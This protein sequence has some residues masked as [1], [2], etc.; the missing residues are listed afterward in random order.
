MGIVIDILS[1][2]WKFIKTITFFNYTAPWITGICL[3][4]LILL[5]VYFTNYSARIASSL[6]LYIVDKNKDVE[7][8]SQLLADD[9]GLSVWLWWILAVFSI[10][11]IAWIV[12]FFIYNLLTL[13]SSKEKGIMIIF[14]LLHL[15]FIAGSAY[16]YIYYKKKNL[17]GLIERINIYFNKMDMNL[18][19]VYSSVYLVLICFLLLYYK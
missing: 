13:K 17:S 7:I 15:A 2:I 11:K 1:T 4:L 9:F 3:L 8:T 14:G 5:N 10:V 12:I 18:N 16:T 6:G 19:I